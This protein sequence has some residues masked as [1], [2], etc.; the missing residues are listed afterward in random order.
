MAKGWIMWHR[1]ARGHIGGPGYSPPGMGG[2]PG[3][4]GMAHCNMAAHR[5]WAD[6]QE[7]EEA[8]RVS[9]SETFETF[10]L[11]TDRLFRFVHLTAEPGKTYRYQVKILL[12][13]P[14][15]DLTSERLDQNAI[16]AGT[17]KKRLIESKAIE[18]PPITVPRS[19]QVLA[20][21]VMRLLGVC[22]I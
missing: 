15:Y 13:N 6:R 16:Q 3:Q 12:Y 18:T 5:E 14:N 2:P 21:S 9:H 4:W 10:C 19:F 7:W 20:D 17:S 8:H 22:P 1:V 11:I